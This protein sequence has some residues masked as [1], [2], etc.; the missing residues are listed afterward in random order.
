MNFRTV[1]ALIRSSFSK[2]MYHQLRLAAISHAKT[3]PGQC[4]A[5][6][7]TGRFGP[8]GMPVR[9]G[10][11]C[12]KCWSVERQRLFALAI[13]RGD[14][15]IKDRKVVHFAG[16]ISIANLI[17]AKRP[18]SYQVSDFENPLAELQFDIEDIDMPDESVDLLIASHILEHVDDRRALSEIYRVLR[19]EGEFVCMVPIIEG[20][21]ETYEDPS[22]VSPEQRERHFGQ[23]DHVRYY[24]ADLRDRLRSAGYSVREFTAGPE[25]VL[26]YRL[27][28]GE[29]VFIA[30]K[31]Q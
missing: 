24:G 25:D 27:Q 15:A 2:Q 4:S 10:A 7:Y 5:C 28:R 23:W 14:I 3:E 9:T 17:R 18:K 13:E 22:I 20:W 31:M 21:A 26:K 6:G 1:S 19:H 29:K 8:F 11:I 30:R 16:E 12:P